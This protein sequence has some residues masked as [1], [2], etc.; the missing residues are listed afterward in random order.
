MNTYFKRMSLPLSQADE[1]KLVIYDK[2]SKRTHVL[3]ETARFIYETCEHKDREAIV[4]SVIQSLADPSSVSREQ[5]SADVDSVISY[6]LEHR[7]ITEVE[8]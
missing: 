1:G 6:L 5:V 3:N 2:N 8:S 7:L 4:D